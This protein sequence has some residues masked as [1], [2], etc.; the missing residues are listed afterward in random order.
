MS[1]SLSIS[2]LAQTLPVLQS[3]PEW[4]VGTVLRLLLDADGA[5][6]VALASDDGAPAG[7]SWDAGALLRQLDVGLLA[8][9]IESTGD[10]GLLLRVTSP[11]PRLQLELLTPSPLA[12]Q[13]H[14]LEAAIMPRAMQPDPPPWLRAPAAEHAD[15]E[16]YLAGRDLQEWVRASLPAL[17]R[18]WPA[19][20]PF[21]EALWIQTHPLAGLPELNHLSLLL[22]WQ[23]EILGLQL[24]GRSAALEI[25]LILASSV[26]MALAR[27]RWP[28]WDGAL[29]RAGAKVKAWRWRQRRL[30][31]PAQ[32]EAVDA[33]PSLLRL[34]AELLWS[35]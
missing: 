10:T 34:A 23:G 2:P 6:R 30:N 16:P 29:A 3:T 28:H 20:E 13:V 9:L 4:P 1:V 19:A 8:Q 17:A 7:R 21:G 33:D 12:A 24:S 25:D 26:A 15:I 22:P 11:L 27:S 14:E 31:R 35:L 18:G 5:W 32:R